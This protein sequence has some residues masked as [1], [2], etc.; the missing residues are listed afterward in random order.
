MRSSDELILAFNS[1]SPRPRANRRHLVGE[2]QAGAHIG[3]LKGRIEFR[4]QSE[5][6]SPPH[7]GIRFPIGATARQRTGRDEGSARRPPSS[8][9]LV[10]Q[11]PE[12][13]RL[14][15]VQLDAQHLVLRSPRSRSSQPLAR[16]GVAPQLEGR[17]GGAQPGLGARLMLL[18]QAARQRVSSQGGVMT[19]ELGGERCN[20]HIEC[21]C[22][23]VAG[24]RLVRDRLELA[25]RVE[26]EEPS[27]R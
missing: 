3:C 7:R 16:L 6:V 8:I 5:E 4:T 12:H 9:R 18:D 14:L 17:P 2:L 13:Q 19:L 10:S 1:C 11:P 20:R 26:T 15:D 23:A 24:D 22:V 27:A 25:E 21:C